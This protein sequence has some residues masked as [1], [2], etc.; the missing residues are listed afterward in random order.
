MQATPR[1]I[2]RVLWSIILVLAV[3]AGAIAPPGGASAQYY[4]TYSEAPYADLTGLQEAIQRHYQNTITAQLNIYADIA[5]FDTEAN[6]AA[7]FETLN[8]YYIGS[9]GT[10]A[11]P[12]AFAPVD[13][14]ALGAET[15]AYHAT[16]EEFGNRHE[17]AFVQVLDGAYVYQV[18]ALNYNDHQVAI[19]VDEAAIALLEVIIVTPAGI[20]TPATDFERAVSGT[21]DKFPEVGDEVPERYGILNASDSGWL[22]IEIETATPEVADTP[23]GF[24]KD[25]VAIVDRTYG[26]LDPATGE[27]KEE[28]LRAFVQIAESVDPAGAEPAFTSAEAAYSGEFEAGGITLEPAEAGVT[29]DEVTAWTSQTE[30][31]GQQLQVALVL[32]RSGPYVFLVGVTNTDAEA[33]PDPLTFASALAQAI[34]DASAESGPG[35]LADDGASTGGIWDKLPATGDEVLGGL[36]AYADEQYHP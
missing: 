14:P 7:G 1:R 36:V 25:F 26:T 35:E 15:R 5:R 4:P 6:A 18:M 20:G 31:E 32:V 27:P 13:G 24:S 16:V 30:L 3:I 19:A 28:G 22:E 12:L 2:R 21:W 11:S 34:V 9:F 10:A 33:E 23:F 17:A 29:A 8:A